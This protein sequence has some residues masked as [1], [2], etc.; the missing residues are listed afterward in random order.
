MTGLADA[1]RQNPLRGAGSLPRQEA[2]STLRQH[3]TELGPARSAR[4]VKRGARQPPGIQA[5]AA[6][7]IV[8]DAGL[9]YVVLAP[10]PNA[11]KAAGLLMRKSWES[12]HTNPSSPYA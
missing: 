5:G 7:P 9:V 10:R 8:H 2:R 1:A 11:A 12:N 6:Q 4:Q 3:A